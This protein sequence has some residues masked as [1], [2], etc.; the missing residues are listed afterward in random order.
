MNLLNM[1]LMSMRTHKSKI[2]SKTKAIM[3]VHVYGLTVDVDPILELAKKYNLKIIEDAVNTIGLTYKGIQC[4]KS[5]G[6]I[7]IFGLSV[8]FYN[9]WK[10]GM[11]LCDNSILDKEESKSLGIF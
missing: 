4:D 7:D 6:D 9:N 10:G 3:I 2:T 11:V 5:F 8:S 1:M